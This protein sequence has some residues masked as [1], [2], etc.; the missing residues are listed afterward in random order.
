MKPLK[1]R[2]DDKYYYNIQ[3]SEYLINGV[4]L[5][6]PGICVFG[7]QGGLEASEYN[8]Y[9]FGDVFLRSYYS[10]YDFEN[11]RIGLA[12]HPYSTGFIDV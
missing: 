1:F 10:I 3:P 8:F 2:F 7:V 9:I 4:D 12:I 5:D 11:K 6:I